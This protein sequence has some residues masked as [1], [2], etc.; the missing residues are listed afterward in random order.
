MSFLINEIKTTAASLSR[1]PGFV[2]TTVF[3]LSLTLG[4]LLAAFSLNHLLIFK[5]LPYPDAQNL[6]LMEQELQEGER[7]YSGSQYFVA[8][9]LMYQQ[10]KSLTSMAL[11]FR[12]SAILASLRDKPLTEISY[13]TPEYFDMLGVPVALGRGFTEQENIDS[14]TANALISEQLWREQYGADANIIGQ[15]ITL[16][17]QQYKIVGVVAA[18]FVEPAN[19][20]D[21]ANSQIWLP[22]DFHGQNEETWNY[23]YSQ[24][25]AIGKLSPATTIDQVSDEF[26]ALVDP[27][28]QQNGRV[29]HAKHQVIIAQFQDLQVAIVGDNKYIALLILLGAGVLL[30]IACANI[31]N[32]FFSRAAQRQRAL[33]IQATLGAKLKHLFFTIWLES[34]LLCVASMVIG[35]VI[36]GW[37]IKLLRSVASHALPRLAELS[38][39][40]T[41]IAFACTLTLTL[42][43]IF[44]VI[45]LKLINH[46]Q[47]I[48]QLQSSGKG[49]GAQVNSKVRNT[50]VASQI[51]LATLLLIV[52]SLVM[53]NALKVLNHPLGFED[54]NLYN[55]RLDIGEGYP[56]KESK[57]QLSRDLLAQLK[58]MNGVVNISRASNA[59]IRRGSNNT[60][61]FNNDNVKLGHFA[62]VSI[63]DNYFNTVGL[64]ILAGRSYNQQ[65]IRNDSDTIILSKTAATKVVAAMGDGNGKIEDIIGKVVYSAGGDTWTVIGVVDNVYNPYNHEKS[66]GAKM[67]FG[68]SRT[69]FIIRMQAGN[70]LAK[71]Q[72]INLLDEYFSDIKVWQFTSV[73]DIHEQ[74]VYQKKLTL[75]LSLV[76]GIF[77]LLLAAVGIYGVISYNSQMRRYELG[78]RMSLGAK[79]KR[80]LLEFIGESLTPIAAG[81]SLSLLLAV[82]LYSW[83]Q[84]HINQWLSFDWVMISSSLLVLITIAL[85]ACYFPAKKIIASDPIK[86]LRNE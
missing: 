37:S 26:N 9:K 17:E 46:K 85:A 55:L 7:K 60:G 80:I 15:S 67:Y 73:S 10:Q 47:L 54:E 75:W 62:Y 58:K 45:T 77:A 79:S 71:T 36:A 40:L 74:L 19:F 83:A 12:S 2:L 16:G 68:S 32:L 66:Q 30:L 53:T 86:A 48:S 56:E 84:Q 8:Q 69:N 39:D 18:S 21:D 81:F 14:N 11:V 34:L 29:G 22:W 59:P 52:T 63:D 61:L 76:L 13:V 57:R 24:T 70:T 31:V 23:V 65:D 50:L 33:V 1:V 72:I 35:L 27:I 5:A 38:L 44:A 64:K 20:T 41:A 28:F 42:S 43:L 82:I 25:A 6:I 49:T 51:C 3:T 4:V 78:I